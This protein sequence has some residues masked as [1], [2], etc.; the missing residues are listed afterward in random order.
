V[1]SET[2]AS[3]ASFTDSTADED[4][5]AADEIYIGFPIRVMGIFLDIVSGYHNDGSASTLTVSYWSGTAWTAYVAA[6]EIT[7]GTSANS[8]TFAQSGEIRLEDK[9]TSV[10]MSTQGGNKIPMYWYKLTFS[11]KCYNDTNNEIRIWR[12]RGVP[13]QRVLR[14]YNCVLNFKDR[15][16]LFGPDNAPN[17]ADYSSYKL[18]YALSGFDTS[19]VQPRITFGDADDIVAAV[20]FYNEAIVFK[21]RETWMMEGDGPQTFGTLLL[22]PYLGCIAPET[23]KVVRTWVTT[24][25][26][27]KDFRY[28]VFFQSYDGVYGCDGIKCW[29]VSG[30]IQNYF[31][32]AESEAIKLG[33]RDDS[34]AFFDPLLNEYHLFIWSGSTPTL[35]EFVYNTELERWAGPWV[36]GVDCVCGEAVVTSGPEM[37]TYGG[38]DDGRLYHLECNS[39]ADV[40]A[41]G[42]NAA[43]NNYVTVA[44][45]WQTLQTRWAH[46]GLYVFGV[47]QSSGSITITLY[48]DAATSG[49]TLG[50]IAMTNSGYGNFYGKLPIGDTDSG[51]T[52]M[53]NK[54]QSLRIRFGLNTVS[55]RQQL[56]GYVLQRAPTGF[57]DGL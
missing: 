10:V 46:R 26:G 27:R 39:Y 2:S 16:F 9:G 54:F 23:A 34:S 1:I 13:A 43:I 28:A 17:I 36:R 21:R 47:A 55:V 14:N 32:P 15:L 6:D 29:K 3:Y 40:D 24:S 25:E 38:G 20:K 22:D 53:E 37:H 56:F 42:T 48:G 33:S 57:A 12:V 11:A 50:T 5:A 44:D 4:I 31:D 52:A 51:G 49:T 30:D 41:S 7:D 19:S 35:Y 45:D 8:K 18:P